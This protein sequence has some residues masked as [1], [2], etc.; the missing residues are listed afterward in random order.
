MSDNHRVLDYVPDD[1]YTELGFIEAVS[2][3]HGLLRFEYRPFVMAERTKL[4]TKL[5]KLP[6]HEEDL[7]VAKVLVE[8]LRGWSLED[9][10]GE[11]ASISLPIVGNLR[12]ALFSRLWGIVSGVFASDI[13]PLWATEQDEEDKEAKAEAS[14]AGVSAGVAKEALLEKNS[15]SG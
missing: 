9:R 4:F 1:G 8:R 14:R 5:Q 3:L 15:D 13:D 12:P 6:D 7:M 11:P 2:G 10:D